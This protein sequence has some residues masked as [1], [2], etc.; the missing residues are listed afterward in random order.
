MPSKCYSTKGNS[1]CIHLLKNK[2]NMKNDKNMIVK[3]FSK[4]NGEVLVGFNYEIKVA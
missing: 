2:I 4:I 3:S 1:G